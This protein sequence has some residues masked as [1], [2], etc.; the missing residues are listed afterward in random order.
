MSRSSGRSGL[1]LAV[2]FLSLYLHLP[3]CVKRCHYCGCNAAVP[4]KRSDVDRYL[5][6]LER[7]LHRLRQEAERAQERDKGDEADALRRE[8]GHLEQRL[9]ELRADRQGQEKR[10]QEGEGRDR[11]SL[12]DEVKE[13]RE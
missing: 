13:L 10:E 6:H 5:D 4:D 3:Y 9:T 7:E 11:E 12:R 2:L 8:A 1:I